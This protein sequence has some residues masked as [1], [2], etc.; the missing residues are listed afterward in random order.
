MIVAGHVAA[1]KRRFEELG[2]HVDAIFVDGGGPGGGVID[3]LRRSGHDVF[4]VQF[5]GSPNKSKIYKYKTDEIWGD[6]REAMSKLCLP[7][8][9]SEV[10]S[11]LRD[12]LTQREYGFTVKDQLIQ[13]ES[14]KDMKARQINSPDIADALALT[15]AQDIEKS[16]FA[17][18]STTGGSRL[19][20]LHEYDPL[21]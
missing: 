20:T 9:K 17:P 16:Q 11:E 18:G 8:E 15:F 19:E 12:Q 13:L 3:I 10:G 6:M 5:G 2:K 4:E 14:K 21:A 1:M 7:G